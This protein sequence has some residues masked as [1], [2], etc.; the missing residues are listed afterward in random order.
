VRVFANPRDRP[1]RLQALAVQ[2]QWQQGHRRAAAILQQQVRHAAALGQVRVV[3]QFFRAAD[4]RERNTVRLQFRRQLPGIEVGEN[5]GQVRQQPR[6]LQ[7]PVIVGRQS[8]VVEQGG[9]AQQLAQGLPLAFTRGSDEHLLAAREGE[10]VVDRP[11]TDPVGHR[12]RGL[13]GYHVLLHVLGREQHAVFVQCT[14]HFAADTRAVALIE[15][16]QHANGAEHAAHDVVHR[17]AGAQG[18]AHRPGHVGQ[19]RHHLHHFIQGQAVVVRATEEALVRGIDQPGVTLAERGVIETQRV[20][21]PGLEVFDEH[22]G[23][24]DQRQHR[25]SALGRVEVDGDALLVA[26]EGTEEPRPR[27]EQPACAVTTGGLDLDHF[28]TQVAKDHAAGGA[29]DHV[30]NLDDT[31]AVQRESG[32]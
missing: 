15:R 16:G 31:N 22:V 23:A 24:V 17:T 9:L 29:H 2:R 18:A 11:G 3:E 30:R 25:L 1:A 10:H 12:R 21:A 13:A 20:H 32:H 14:L 6:P 27:P 28:G 8:R 26:V 19:A 7:H 4:R 5:L